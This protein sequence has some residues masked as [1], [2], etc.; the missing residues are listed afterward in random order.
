MAE[1]LVTALGLQPSPAENPPSPTEHPPTPAEHPA[2]PSKNPPSPTEHPPTPAEHPA[3]PAVTFTDIADIPY[4]ASIQ[5][6]ADAG[7][8]QGCTTTTFC[9]DQT[10]TRM[11]IDKFLARALGS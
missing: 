1:F 2:T 9:P 11:Q 6:L 8:A 10:I 3:T 4:A 5:A 7:I